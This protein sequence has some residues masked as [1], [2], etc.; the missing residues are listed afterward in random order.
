MDDLDLGA[1]SW[2]SFDFML[3]DFRG[4]ISIEM[5]D[6]TEVSFHDQVITKEESERIKMEIKKALFDDE[7]VRDFVAERAEFLRMHG[8]KKLEEEQGNS[9]SSQSG[10]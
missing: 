7:A 6:G 5:D 2:E 10:L 8:E 1:F 9:P 4:P 3:I